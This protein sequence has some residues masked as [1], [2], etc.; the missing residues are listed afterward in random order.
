VQEVCGALDHYKFGVVLSNEESFTVKGRPF[1]TDDFFLLPPS[2]NLHL[3]SPTHGAVMAVSIKAEVFLKEMTLSPVVLEWVLGLGSQIGFMRANR[4]ARRLREDAIAAIEGFSQ[5]GGP[6]SGNL[7]GQ[8][9]VASVTSKLALEWPGVTAQDSGRRGQIYDRFQRCRS[10]L[11]S[12]RAMPNFNSKEVDFEGISKRSVEQ[13]FSKTVSMGPLTYHR[14]LRLHD[15][16]RQLADP[17]GQE[18]SIGDIAAAHGFWDWSR[19]SQQYR[20]HFGELPSTTRQFQ[21]DRT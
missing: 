12:D 21:V 20:K 10:L 16:R 13:S 17:N 5:A 14:I 19:F 3:I 2:G 7:I 4:F 15:V 11:K 9:F 6:S 1:T 18:S 8:A